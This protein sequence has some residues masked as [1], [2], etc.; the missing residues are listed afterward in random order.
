MTIMQEESFDAT[1][2]EGRLL[3]ILREKGP[4]T[5]D[6]LC[7][8]P[9]MSWSQVLLAVDHLSRIQEVNLELMATHEYLVSLVE[10]P[11]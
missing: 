2:C 5:L 11:R 1:T 8:L 6:S 9:D 7:S 3:G 10:R 4:Q